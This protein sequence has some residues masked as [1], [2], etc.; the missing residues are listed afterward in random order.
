MS[1][2]EVILLAFFLIFFVL[3]LMKAD[4]AYREKQTRRTPRRRTP[5]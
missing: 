2:I 4:R 3:I 1:A 5:K